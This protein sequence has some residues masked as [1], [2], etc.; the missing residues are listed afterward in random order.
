MK[1]IIY[2]LKENKILKLYLSIFSFLNLTCLY[3]QVSK[4]QYAYRY[5]LEGNI[6]MHHYE[7]LSSISKIPS[8]LETFIIIIYLVYL[9]KVLIKKDK[10]NINEFLIINLVL[11]G[12]LYFI[13]YMISIIFS[14]RIWNLTMQLYTPFSLTF[15]AGVYL[16]I[17]RLYKKVRG[18]H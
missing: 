13:N 14:A 18:N 16:V 9:I 15:I 6:E 17:K 5:S 8:L 3:F 1:G 11:F 7:Y 2:E 10:I 4:S 12:F